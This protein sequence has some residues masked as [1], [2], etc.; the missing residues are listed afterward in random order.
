MRNRMGKDIAVEK[1][2]I[3]FMVKRVLQNVEDNYKT[4]SS[5]PGCA[6][7]FKNVDALTGGMASQTMWVITGR[8]EMGK[9]AFAANLAA[10]AALR[11]KKKVAI[12][13]ADHPSSDITAR[14]ISS[15]TMVNYS[16][17][18]K[19]LIYEHEWQK[20]VD[21]CSNLVSND[22]IDFFENKWLSISD[23]KRET[24]RGSYDIVIID[25]FH[26]LILKEEA[27]E[28]SNNRINELNQSA[29]ELKGIA[30]DF[31][32]AMILICDINKGQEQKIDKRPTLTDLKDFGGVLESY[33]DVIMGIYRPELYDYG[34]PNSE[35]RAE[36][37]FLKNRF[38]PNAITA[39]NFEKD[40]VRKRA[41]PQGNI[42]KWTSC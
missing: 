37:L 9:T 36:A 39:L 27:S 33:A 7:G 10:H 6:T 25:K 14:I 24:E 32:L 38:G 42:H 5:N 26:S 17:F 29:I 23:I 15:E 12:F 13:T 1:T 21:V 19:G 40:N 22:S 41:S 28:G 34:N 16:D 11:E 18:R 20:I 4:K 8:P 30:R 31:S 2:N 35:G 3:G